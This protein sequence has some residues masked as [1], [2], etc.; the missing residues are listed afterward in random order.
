MP[1]EN[2]VNT[3]ILFFL[4]TFIDSFSL[5]LKH[6]QTITLLSL[7]FIMAT[8][9]QCSICK[10]T[11]TFLCNGCSKNFCFDHLTEH[12]QLLNEQLHSIQDDYNQFRQFIIDIKENPQ[13]HPLITKIDQW[14][15]ESIHKIKQTAQQ[16]REELI[17]YTNQNIYQIEIKLNDSNEEIIPNQKKNDFNEISLNNFKQKLEKLK[18]ELNQSK[19]ISILQQSDSLINQISIKFHSKFS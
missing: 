6:I 8:S 5:S 17:N 12:Q 11:S 16:C 3:S 19:D 13:K 10:E 14:E 2:R 15:N 9:T 7:I 18:Q 4:L 1:D